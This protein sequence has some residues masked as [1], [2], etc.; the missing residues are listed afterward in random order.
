MKWSRYSSAPRVGG[1]SAR[2]SR[3]LYPIGCGARGVSTN[4]FEHWLGRGCWNLLCILIIVYNKRSRGYWVHVLI[5]VP[6]W[7]GVY[8]LVRLVQ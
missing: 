7:L 4:V 3:V 1:P 6:F 5:Y 2:D 8:D